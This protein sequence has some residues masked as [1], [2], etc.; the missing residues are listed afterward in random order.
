MPRLPTIRVTGSHDMSTMLRF[1]GMT[2][3][4]VA[5]PTLLISPA[6]VVPGRQLGAVM[7]PLRFLV[8]GLVGVPAHQPDERSVGLDHHSGDRGAGWLV[9]ERHELV[10]EA[11]HRAGDADSPDVRA[12]ADPVHPATLRHVA[13]DDWPPATELHEALGRVVVVRE[14]GLLVVPSAVA[15]FVDGLAE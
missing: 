4:R 12:A 1:S 6:G 10:G 14:V 13:V 9:H 3:S 11:G 8:R 2:R 15:A 7:A 5:I